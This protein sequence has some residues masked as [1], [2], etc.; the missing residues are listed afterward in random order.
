MSVPSGG[1]KCRGLN[2]TVNTVTNR[3][4]TFHQI[5]SPSPPT[6]PT[7]HIDTSADLGAGIAAFVSG[8]SPKIAAAVGAP[9]EHVH[10]VLR[11]SQC[12]TW[13]SKLGGVD[14]APHTAQIR[15]VCGAELA[16]EVKA[17][18]VASVGGMLEKFVPK[19]STQVP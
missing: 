15:V 12:M 17:K 8:A 13:G 14:G 4:T 7:L 11:C 10:I 2:V 5:E 9:K 1:E 19:A 18:V 3:M 6:M 16:A